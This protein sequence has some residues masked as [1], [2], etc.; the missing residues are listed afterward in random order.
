MI[1]HPK[2]Q[3]RKKDGG[4]GEQDGDGDVGPGPRITAWL[5]LRSARL[6][7]DRRTLSYQPPDPNKFAETLNAWRALRA[8]TWGRPI[9]SGVPG[10]PPYRHRR[11]RTGSLSDPPSSGAGK[12]RAR[13]R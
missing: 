13:R 8:T 9:P 10:M 1:K 7:A 4:E 2:R 5:Q 3:V 12:P 6:G 11:R